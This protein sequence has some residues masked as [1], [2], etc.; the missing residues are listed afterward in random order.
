MTTPNKI[1]VELLDCT[2]TADAIAE[3]VRIPMLVVKS[4]LERHAKDGL[5]ASRE[6]ALITWSI[7]PDGRTLAESLQAPCTP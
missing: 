5:V 1:L 2:A 4:M 3:R 7:T 6:T